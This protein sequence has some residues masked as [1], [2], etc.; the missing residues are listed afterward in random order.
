MLRVFNTYPLRFYYLEINN[1][2]KN[3]YIFFALFFLS[4]IV[5]A[6]NGQKTIIDDLNTSKSGQGNVKVLQDESI[7]KLVGV[8]HIAS[9]STSS[10]N[11]GSLGSSTNF[12]KVRGFKI[13]AYSGNNQKRSKQEAES[14]QAQIRAAYP[15]LE[16]VITYNAPV[17]RLRVGNFLSRE[18][19]EATLS[20]M[21]KTLPSLG[22]E[23]YVVQDV[24]KRPTE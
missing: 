12:V 17:W 6:Q 23:L 13:Q 14:K 4:G 21:K 20:E 9:A 11:S 16:T 19:A 24:V 10:D 5:L 8:H 3:L 2:K 1:M 22:R 15:E 18:D 7:Q